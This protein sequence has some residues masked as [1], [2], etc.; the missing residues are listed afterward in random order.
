MK[1]QGEEGD[2]EK[3]KAIHGRSH[4]TKKDRDRVESESHDDGLIDSE[5]RD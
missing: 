5:W 4:S 2:R 3:E 1:G